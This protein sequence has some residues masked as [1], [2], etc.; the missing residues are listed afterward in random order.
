MGASAC[1]PHNDDQGDRA[2][3][4]FKKLIANPGLEDP[5]LPRPTLAELGLTRAYALKG[6]K[7]ES[8]NEYEVLFS[9]WR[10]A[11]SDFPVLIEAHRESDH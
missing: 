10:R 8:A 2:E 7:T 4:D 5:S 3:L 1:F 6:R 11:D 9:L